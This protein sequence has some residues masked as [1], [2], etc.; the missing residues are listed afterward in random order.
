MCSARAHV[1]FG[2]IADI[3]VA[4]ARPENSSYRWADT[5]E[6]GPGQAWLRC[7]HLGPNNEEGRDHD[8]D[9]G[10]LLAHCGCFHL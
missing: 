1:R 5:G 6:I 10:Q 4:A 9:N 8:E 3:T 7:D 2:P